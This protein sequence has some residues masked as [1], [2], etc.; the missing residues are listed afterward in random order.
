MY[1][2][3]PENGSDRAGEP[4]APV[5]EVLRDAILRGQIPAGQAT[6]QSMLARDLGVGRTPLREAL[7]MLQRE[8]LVVS[9]PHRSVRVAQLSSSDAEGLYVMRISLESVALRL[10]VPRLTSA[11]I[12]ELEGYMAQMDHYM[13]LQDAPGLRGPHAAFHALLIRYAGPRVTE[14]L[15]QLFDHAERYRLAFGAATSVDWD[16]RREEHRA[17]LDAASAGDVDEA[18]RSLVIHYARTAARIF[19]G[20]EPGHDLA[21]LR[22]TI[23]AT[24]PGSETA[25]LLI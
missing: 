18:V 13:R 25:L 8:G 10:S 21:Q 14:M 1:E 19:Q 15:A 11:D 2:A 7:R 17:I 16:Q 12:A 3:S 5:Y 20:L 6:T 22:E 9:E 4:A 24:A 23:R